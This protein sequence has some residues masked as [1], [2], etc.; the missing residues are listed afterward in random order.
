MIYPWYETL[1]HSDEI[2]Q[3]DLILDCPIIIPPTNFNYTETQ[4]AQI[5]N[6]GEVV[7]RIM[8]LVQD[9]QKSCLA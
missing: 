8:N 6:V 5:P 9:M 3:G 1:N 4:D 2:R 7:V